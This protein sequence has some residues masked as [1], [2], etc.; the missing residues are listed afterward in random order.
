MAYTIYKSDGTLLTTITDGSLDTSTTTLN[1]PGPN[2]VGYGLHLDEN[3]VWLLENFASNTVPSGASL[4]GQLWFNKSDQ[5]LQVFTDQG[6]VAVSGVKIQ[7]SQPFVAKIGDQWFNTS[8]NQLYVY[9]DIAWRLIAPL[10]TKSQGVSGAIPETVNDAGSTGV[11]HNIVKQQFGST[12]VAIFSSS[13]GAFV[14]SPAIEGFPYIYPGLT[15]N[16]ELIDG[17]QQFYTNANTAL[18]LPT[19]PTIIAINAN[20]TA[21]N[22]ALVTANNAVVSYV[23][24]VNSLQVANV[25]AANAAIVTANTAVVSFVGT[26]NSAQSTALLAN[27]NAANAAIVT[28]NNAVVSFVGTLNSAQSTALLANVNAANVAITAA[29]S[30]NAGS[31]QTEINS[32]QT[33]VYSNAKVA[34]YML[35]N[36]AKITAQTQSTDDDSTAVAT[37]AFVY[38]HMPPG[39]IVMW[40]S[41][42]ASIPTGWQLCNGTNGTPDLR[43]RF[44]IG[45]GSSY[46]VAATGG[47]KDAVIV[48]HDHTGTATVNFSGT[49][50]AGGVHTH[51]GTAI[52]E[53]LVGTHGGDDRNAQNLSGIVSG[54]TTNEIIGAT[55]S[56]TGSL[57]TIDATHSHTLS[58]D[59][60]AAHTHSFSGVASAPYTTNARGVSGTNANLP[61]YYALCYIQK[62]A[63]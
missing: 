19:D 55:G 39:I 34:S 24:T 38:N 50:D 8:T 20:V 6:Y 59:N 23:N 61:P 21:A 63:A 29:W 45:A 16:L 27:V 11:T 49:T 32:L 4:Q 33:Q 57:L 44:V 31:Q 22:T 15:I 60:S 26:I 13:E 7:G 42:V 30:A 17:A 47:S 12:T 52:T 51:S 9:D 18:Y 46:A 53:S 58:I 62:M 2:Y 5:S 56:G 10:Y 40:N 43:D 37:T 25:N 54:Y 36:T 41:S 28:A 14:P 35:T 48:S 1:L 3:L